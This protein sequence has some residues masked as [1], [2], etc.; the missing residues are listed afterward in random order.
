[1][2]NANIERVKEGFEAF[3][4]GDIPGLIALQADDTVWDHSGLPG[5]PVNKVFHGRDG[6][7]E[8]FEILAGVQEPLSF[9]PREFFGD[10]DRVVVLGQF[11]WRVHATGKEWESDWAMAYTI[12]DGLVAHWRVIYD[13]S[14]E[15]EALS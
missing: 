3:A 11:S 13:M 10:G 5:N 9:E 8:F 12:R 4:A 2:S 14:K 6:V 15:F 7:A 1:M